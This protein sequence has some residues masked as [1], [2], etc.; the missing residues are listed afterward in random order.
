MAM[1]ERLTQVEQGIRNH[2]ASIGLLIDIADRQQVLLERIDRRLEQVEQD[3]AMT[4]RLWVR[5]AQRYGWL[6]D[7]DWPP[8]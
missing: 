5:L 3:T 1:E 4:R 7:E 6:E 2:D 8:Q